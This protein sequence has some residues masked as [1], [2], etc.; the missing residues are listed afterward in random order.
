[1]LPGAEA[2]DGGGLCGGGHSGG[3]GG[4]GVPEIEMAGDGGF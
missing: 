3:G 4:G 1:M 2:R